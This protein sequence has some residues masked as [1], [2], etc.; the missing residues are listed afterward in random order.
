LTAFFL[1]LVPEAAM[2]VKTLK[3]GRVKK[4][5]TFRVCFQTPHPRIVGSG[6]GTCTGVAAVIGPF[7][8]VVDENRQLL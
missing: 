2:L 1:A 7:L 4:G 6:V 8:L 3:V 5:W